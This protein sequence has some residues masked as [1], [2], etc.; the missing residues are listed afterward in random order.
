MANVEL[1]GASGRT[2][3]FVGEGTEVEV[4]RLVD[5]DLLPSRFSWKATERREFDLLGAAA[6]LRLNRKFKDMLT[7]QARKDIL[8][9]L[10]AEH[11]NVINET[12]ATYSVDAP[13]QVVVD[14]LEARAWVIELKDLSLDLTHEMNE[15]GDRLRLLVAAEEAVAVDPEIMGGR[16]VFKGSRLPIETAIASIDDGVTMSEMI[17]DYPFLS[18]EKIAQARVYLR[19][20]PRA[21]RPRKAAIRGKHEAVRRVQVEKDPA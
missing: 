17:E 15:I 5:D 12:L 7:R 11:L 16:P 1:M 10:E 18:E 21:G 20:H 4:N 3:A 8:A 14:L 2:V 19:V 9:K 6:A 13:C